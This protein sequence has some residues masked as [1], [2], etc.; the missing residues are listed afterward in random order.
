MLKKY[1]LGL[2]L[3]FAGLWNATSQVREI[4]DAVLFGRG[5]VLETQ[6]LS[7]KVLLPPTGE[8]KIFNPKES[9]ANKVVPG[10]GLP[11]IMDP[12]WQK[13]YGKIQLKG[14]SLVFDAA[15]SG[16]TP[17]DPTGAVGPNHYVNAW[18]SAFAIYDKQGNVLLPPAALE[19]I[20]GTFEGEDEGD[21]IVIYDSFADRFLITQ[22]S[23]TPNSFLV[24]ISKGPDPVN[25][26][27]YTYR[28]ETGDR[29]P[30]YP[31]FSVW[32]D[33]YYITT[34]KQFQNSESKEVVYV[35]ERD[36]MLRG[37]EARM[38][39]FPLPGLNVN[40]FYSPAGFF[41]VGEELPPQGNAPIIYFQ[42]DSW[43]GVNQDHLKIW[44][45]NVDWENPE[46][47]T[48]E[49]SQVLGEAEGVAPFISTFDG[50]SFTNLSQAGEYPDVDALQ[51]ALM[52]MTMYRRFPTH[53]SVVMNFVVDIDPSAAEHAGIR[54]YELRQGPGGGPWSVYQEGTYAP[55]ESDRWCGSIG[56]D[57]YGNIG[58][59]FTVL[60]DNPEDP[61]FP[62]LRYTGRFVADELNKMTVREISIVEGPAPNPSFRYGDYS[63]LTIDPV[64]DATFWF[65]GEYFANEGQRKNKVA[66]FK[67]EPEIANDVGIAEII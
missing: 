49:E 58:M 44:L 14:P 7:E 36:K 63:H 61:V 48:I 3:V 2:F 45:I 8:F 47:S 34:N 60:N 9:G 20:G 39:G 23:F 62:S 51:G 6:A 32:S 65:I 64:D 38:V 28:F 4:S 37:E 67:L 29:I 46:N 24:A 5:T 30:D 50:G 19:S 56:I 52:Y 59:G 35:L 22:F 16:S 31:K 17:T 54:W 15:T 10:K 33:G 55:D 11:K 42:D 13:N 53:N 66:V 25:D 41:A 40:A 18:N 57:K 1:F 26:G 27:W 12:V 43:E 21:P